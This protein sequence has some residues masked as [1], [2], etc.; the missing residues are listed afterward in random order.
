MRLSVRMWGNS[1]AIRIPSIVAKEMKI[2]SGS[3]VEAVLDGR[4]LVITPVTGKAT[5]KDLLA[6]VTDKNRHAETNTGRT[7]G[8]EVW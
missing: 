3:E 7:L 2:Q 1:L 8:K 6:R 4:N 5:L